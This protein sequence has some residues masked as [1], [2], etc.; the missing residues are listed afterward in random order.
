MDV[1]SG[2]SPGCLRRR[3]DCDMRLQA[4]HVLKGIRNSR[5]MG[6]AAPELRSR[7]TMG[8][9]A[10]IGGGWVENWS[11]QVARYIE[12]FYCKIIFL[13]SGWRFCSQSKHNPHLL[14][15]SAAKPL[16]AISFDRLI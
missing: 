9:E 8:L 1:K 6:R 16:S 7:Y 10:F 4:G 2:L 13:R 15:I 11:P 3:A 14:L 12:Y 5:A